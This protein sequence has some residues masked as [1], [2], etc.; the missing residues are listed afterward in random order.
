M[1][2]IE[3]DFYYTSMSHPFSLARDISEIQQICH[4][5]ADLQGCDAMSLSEQFAM[6]QRNVVNRMPHD[7]ASRPRNPTPQQRGCH[8]LRPHIYHISVYLH[9]T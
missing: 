7:T 2:I 9:V 3:T 4:E 8:D 5:L 6:F 1:V